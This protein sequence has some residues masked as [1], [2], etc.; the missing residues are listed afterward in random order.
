MH[1][2]V[3]RSFK[4]LQDNSVIFKISNSRLLTSLYPL[5]CKMLLLCSSSLGYNHKNIIIYYYLFSQKKK[6]IFQISAI[7]STYLLWTHARHDTNQAMCYRLFTGL[8][9]TNCVWNVCTF[10]TLM[11]CLVKASKQSV[12]ISVLTFSQYCDVVKKLVYWLLVIIF[13]NLV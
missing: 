7:L 5:A 1:S 10:S 8:F 13:L 6:L 3:F 9:S 11:A 4:L 12:F 2:L